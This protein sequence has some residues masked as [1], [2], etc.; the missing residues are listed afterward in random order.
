MTMKK[1][2]TTKSP[3]F[4]GVVEIDHLL[5]LSIWSKN[6]DDEETGS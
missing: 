4:I 6:L 2:P 1:S 3:D 5:Q